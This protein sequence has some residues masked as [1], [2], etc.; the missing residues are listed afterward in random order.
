MEES[1]YLVII[2]V[3]LLLLGVAI[4]IF[5]LGYGIFTQC[6]LLGVAIYVGIIC[7][8]SGICFITMD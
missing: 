1:D 8:L 5:L 2:G 7:I 3:I 4:I 6:G